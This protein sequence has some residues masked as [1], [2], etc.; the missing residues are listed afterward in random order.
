MILAPY[1]DRWRKLVSPFRAW[2]ETAEYGMAPIAFSIKKRRQ[3]QCHQLGRWW[4]HSS[5]MQR[6]WFWPNSWNLGKPSLLLVMSRLCTSFVVRC[7]IN[8]RDETLSSC[9]TTLAPTLLASYQKQLQRW[10]VKFFH[11]PPIAL[12]WH[13][14]T[15]IFSDLWRISCADSVMRQRRQFGKQCVSVFGWL[16]RN[17][18]E[19]EF[20][21]SQNA[22]RNVYK[23][24]VIMWKNKGRSV[25]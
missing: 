6:G 19:G 25:D 20:S 22:W 7:A 2:N 17:F 9:M 24:V 5:G 21:N 23:E 13:P 3:R 4:A 10:G 14:P 11:T 15:T 1:C 18:T 12:I 8:V 16:E